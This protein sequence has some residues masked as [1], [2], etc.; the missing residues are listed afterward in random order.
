MNLKRHAA[1]VAE[2]L[3]YRIQGGLRWALS[4]LRLMPPAI[5]KAEPTQRTDYFHYFET[6]ARFDAIEE[7][8][9]PVVQ[10][11]HALGT[12]TKF[13]CEGH[14]LEDYTNYPYVLCWLSPELARTLP[15]VIEKVLLA[16]LHYHWYVETEDSSGAKVRARESGKP[17]L[18]LTLRGGH[19]PH[20]LLPVSDVYA[21]EFIK[22][23]LRAD[24]CEIA[25]RLNALE[26]PRRSPVVRE[27]G[28]LPVRILLGILLA[29]PLV[30][31]NVT[32]VLSYWLE[33]AIGVLCLKPLMQV[34]RWVRRLLTSRTSTR[35][36][37]PGL[38][39]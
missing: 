2:I 8:V 33:T 27:R 29:G 5:T 36:T 1:E 24:L 30:L 7:G 9:L 16:P 26:L 10:A 31:L 12:N 25:Q 11:L 6:A 19:A 37:Q 13:S 34:G 4:L 20:R 39:G 35:S 28:V 14:V 3:E 15:D 18:F 17:G 38:D 22:D 21:P 23:W 32:Y